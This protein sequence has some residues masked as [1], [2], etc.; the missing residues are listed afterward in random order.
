[1]LS[2]S[3]KTTLKSSKRSRPRKSYLSSLSNKTGVSPILVRR[4]KESAVEEE[5]KQPPCLVKRFKKS[6]T[7]KAKSTKSAIKKNF[8]SFAAKPDQINTL[9]REFQSESNS[10]PFTTSSLKKLKAKLKDKRKERR[11]LK[12]NKYK[13]KRQRLRNQNGDP[14]RTKN[15]SGEE[16]QDMCPFFGRAKDVYQGVPFFGRSKGD[17]DV[18]PF[19]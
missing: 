6:F 13:N 18:V 19:F 12:S 4:N 1:M 2:D 8:V 14:V 16:Q 9:T 7:N 5:E 15:N 11:K 10:S 17:F 3:S